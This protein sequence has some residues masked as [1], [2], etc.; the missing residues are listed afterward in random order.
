MS[1][2]I[3]KLYFSVSLAGLTGFLLL[4]LAVSF[5][6]C[7]DSPGPDVTPPAVNS[8]FIYVTGAY[9]S[10]RKG[11]SLEFKATVDVKGGASRNVTWSLTSA[12]H[13]AGTGIHPTSGLLTVD[14]EETKNSITVKATPVQPGFADKAGEK[15]V[16]V[17]GSVPNVVYPEYRNLVMAGYQGWF[18]TPNDG[19]NRNWHHYDF[20]GNDSEGNPTRATID[21]WPDM[22]E[23]SKKY[24]SPFKMPDGSDSYLYSPYDEESVDLHFKWME[25]YG[26]DGVFMQRFV[27]EVNN[28]GGKNH[29]NKVL[30][31]ALKAAKKYNRAIGVMY[32]LSGCNA[33]N[34]NDAPAFIESDWLDL[35]QRFKLGDPAENPTYIHHNGRP[36]VTIWG[37]GFNDNR[38]YT[39][40]DVRDVVVKLKNTHGVSIMLGIPYWWER[41]GGDTES[42]P[43]LHTLIK[44]YADII[45]PW[46]VGRY[47]IGAYGGGDHAAKLEDDIAWC[48]ANGITYVPLVFPGFSWGN[49]QQSEEQA[50]YHQTPRLKGDFL[51]KQVAGAKSIGAQS[52]YVAMFDE[53][54]EGTAIYK[55]ANESNVPVFASGWRKFIGIEDDLDTDYYLWLV[56]E[57]GKWFHGS[58]G[59]SAAKPVRAAGSISSVTVNGPASVEKGV[60]A[61]YTAVVTG[62]GSKTV[63]WSIKETNKHAATAINA[64]GVLTVSVSETLNSLTIVAVSTVDT[65][66]RHE[67]PVAV[68]PPSLNPSLYEFYRFTADG[69]LWAEVNTDDALKGKNQLVDDN[70]VLALGPS[71]ANQ[72]WV[73]MTEA[74]GL[75]FTLENIRGRKFFIKNAATG[76]YVNVKGITRTHF[77][78]AASAV[79]VKVSFFENT[80]DFKWGVAPDHISGDGGLNGG[81]SFYNGT[82]STGGILSFLGGP[83]NGIKPSANNSSYTAVHYLHADGAQ[84]WDNW[85]QQGPINGVLEGRNYNVRKA[86]E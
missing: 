60:P 58:P 21:F 35:Q 46:A 42:N 44:E 81:C 59:Y 13:A 15:T 6:A 77:N 22:T 75:T 82:P 45:M 70:G 28:P 1:N 9:T 29:F 78:N 41:L 38:R 51:W 25:E 74:Q 52:L 8:V 24:L 11:G 84:D 50:H 80:E 18:N 79:Q 62:T 61:I 76:N 57:A 71:S 27:M 72:V 68:L 12:G 26:I 33:S 31:N 53:I 14:R 65:T 7:K 23:Y 16:P 83:S 63:T 2:R 4:I 20:G 54:D 34:A 19:A 85:T 64:A 55:C 67:F 10:V 49:M 32:D 47:D 73:L 40:A 37:V 66:K 30:E 43:A 48:A 69:W 17:T 39:T 36:L 5:T 56:G 86:T 3:V